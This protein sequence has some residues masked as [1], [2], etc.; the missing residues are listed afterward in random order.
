[1]PLSVSRDVARVARLDA[2]GDAEVGHA[3]DAVDADEDVLRRHVPV[4]EARARVRRRRS[5]SCA[6]CR[7]AHAS[8]T[9]RTA[10]ARRDALAL[11]RADAHQ[12]AQRGALDVV[13]DELDGV[14]DDL[15]VAHVDDVGVVDPGR[16]PR[17]AQ[18]RVAEAA[19]LEQVRVRPLDGDELPEAEGALQGSEEHRGHAARGDLEEGLVAVG[20]GR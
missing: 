13:H 17:L 5:S 10:I 18:Q 14:A 11:A 9:T 3:R 7:P 12:V 1:M 6:A 20:D 2:L 8:S 4:H 16:E 15:D 19:V